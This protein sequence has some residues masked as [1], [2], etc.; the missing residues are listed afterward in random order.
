VF[1]HKSMSMV[2][3]HT[4][5]RLFLAAFAVS[6]AFAA[7]QAPP[8]FIPRGVGGGGA[9]FAPSFSPHRP[10]ELFIACDMSELLH[11]SD[12]GRRWRTVDFR[13]IQG[14]RGSVVHFTSSPSL[15]YTIDFSSESGID[16]QRPVRSLDG[17]TTWTNL[18]SDPTSG[19]TYAMFVDPDATNRI[20]VSSYFNLYSSTNGGATFQTAYT[21]GGNGLF[22]SG[23]FF[24]GN[25]IYLGSS[26]GVLLSTNRGSSF[27]LL[28]VP[29]IPPTDDILSF[30][31]ARTGDVTRLF[32]ITVTNET[33]YPGILIEEAYYPASQYR[34]I[35]TLDVGA[36]SWVSRAAG[37]ASDHTPIFTG[38]SRT[39][40]A[41]LWLAGQTS[42]ENP[43]VY[44]STNGGATWTSTFHYQSNSNVVTG[45]CGSQGDREYTYDA[46]FVGFGVSPVDPLTA[47]IT[48]YGFV[49]LTTNGGALWRQGYVDTAM[50]NA[51]GAHTPK[52]KSYNSIGLENTSCWGLTWLSSN[53]IIAS[54]SDIRGLRST[55][56]GVSWSF[57]YSGHT[58]NTMY[59]AVR[60]TNGMVYAGVGSAHDLY[61]STYLQ[62]SRIDGATGEVL[63]STNRGAAWMRLRNFTNIVY[64]LA[65][66]PAHTSRLYA[67]V[68]H[69]SR[70]G[71]Y[72]TSNLHAGASAT[73]A[74]LTAP[75]RTEGHPHQ[76][77]VLQDRTLVCS[78]SGR[79]DA[80][81][82]FTASS[83]IFVST[84]GGSTW[85]D[86]SHTNMYYWTK[87]IVLDP[88]DAGQSNWYAGVF[89]GWG[90][91][92]NDK[93]GLYRTTNRGISWTRIL[94]RHR[95]TSCTFHPVRTNELYVTTETEG[96]WIS[97][98]ARAA[99]PAFAQ[100][101]S[102]P[103]RQP[104]R[105]FVNP[106]DPEQ[107]W[108]TSFGHGLRVGR[109]KTTPPVIRGAVV[110]GHSARLAWDAEPG[111]TYSLQ[112]SFQSLEGFTTVFSNGWNFDPQ[113]V[114]RRC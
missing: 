108:V 53:E 30:S 100:V 66:D 44:R 23:A 87:D 112:R 4:M 3:F 28:N 102:Y 109:M 73:W 68:V 49:H 8:Y 67:A 99:S 46:S 97:T 78:Y 61:Q 39:N 56:A 70:G 43:V 101:A 13:E 89:S 110:E 32:C 6:G 22:L 74:R 91:P 88:H 54:Y 86:R 113:M 26:A 48:G 85:I 92:P 10:G 38:M 52:G 106:Y 7:A 24:D 98:N 111:A 35:Y 50:E 114:T 104:E 20:L 42:S 65:L 14:N 1:N 77:H 64:Q 60:H 58:Y 83:G 36:T 11:S 55:N 17:G 93:G 79:R 103:F 2:G 57:D 5:R 69:S 47:A 72:V 82:V 25:R 19:E 29:G 63:F 31:G 75:P 81:G 59:H 71:W 37:I 94:N 80:G 34:G 33:L 45:W 76:L 96:L 27:S 15:L 51:S 95:I 18:P 105:V 40:T 16:L 41:T 9:L 84:N 21:V 12:Y 107:L 62:D 90:G